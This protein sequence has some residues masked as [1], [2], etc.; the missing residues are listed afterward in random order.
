MLFVKCVAKTQK[1]T[2]KSFDLI[3]TKYIIS[4]QSSTKQ[5]WK[6]DLITKKHR[7]S[8]YVLI[9]HQ[10]QNIVIFKFITTLVE[11]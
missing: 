9:K 4:H 6:I 11:L 7:L 5:I 8:W 10:L 1:L 3:N 2:C